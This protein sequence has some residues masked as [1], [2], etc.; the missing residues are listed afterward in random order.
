[1][2]R[3][4]LK[5]RSRMNQAWNQS[6]LRGTTN[7][8]RQ[9]RSLRRK[10]FLPLRSRLFSLAKILEP[11]GHSLPAQYS[12]SLI[13]QLLKRLVHAAASHAFALCLDAVAP[14]E[15]RLCLAINISVSFFLPRT[16]EPRKLPTP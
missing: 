9:T 12:T 2:G 7:L 11:Q 13:L 1:M 8:L 4:L 5:N 16:T 14:N 10:R 3:E 6:S 15:F